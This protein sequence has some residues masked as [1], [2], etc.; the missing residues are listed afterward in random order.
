MKKL[1][2][3]LLA[4]REKLLLRSKRY[5][6]I[7]VNARCIWCLPAFLF[8]WPNTGNQSLNQW[9][10]TWGDFVSQRTSNNDKRFLV[11]TTRNTLLAS[12]GE[13]PGMLLNIQ[14]CTGGPPQQRILPVLQNV[15]S[16]EAEKSCSRYKNKI[17]IVFSLCLYP[18]VFQKGFEAI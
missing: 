10:S 9:F 2:I 14:Q 15:L 12:S 8:F 11:V 3:A 18:N 13:R 5:E 1:R 16:T 4:L 6:L 17:F 7:I